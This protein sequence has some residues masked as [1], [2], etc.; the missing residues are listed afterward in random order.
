MLSNLLNDLFVLRNDPEVV[1]VCVRD[2]AVHHDLENAV[3]PLLE[4]GLDA[5]LPLYLSR[6]T[7]GVREV[8]SFSTVLDSDFHAAYSS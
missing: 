3:V 6:Q 7:G 8:V 1:A 2:A 5:K 4:L